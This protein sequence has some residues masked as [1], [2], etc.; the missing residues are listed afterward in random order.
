MHIGRTSKVI[1]RVSKK[2]LHEMKLIKHLCSLMLVVA[3]ASIVGACADTPGGKSVPEFRVYAMDAQSYG[4]TLEIPDTDDTENQDMT[5]PDNNLDDVS[6]IMEDTDRISEIKAERKSEECDS[7]PVEVRIMAV[8]D[9]LIHMPVVNAGKNE[10]GTYDYKEMYENILDEINAADLRVINQETILTADREEYSGYPC[11]GSPYEIGD[12]LIASG[13]NLVTCATNHSYDKKS[14]GIEDSVS[15]WKSHP[16][17]TAIGIYNSQD[18]FDEIAVVEIN[19]IRIACLNY[20]YGLNGFVLPSDRQYMVK[21]LYDKDAVAT[22]VRKADEI[23]DFVI[24]FPHWGTEYTH[25][26][27]AYQ[28]E[29]A[30]TFADNGA[31][32]II[33]THP[34]VIEPL[35]YI[36]ADDGHIVPCYYSLGNFISAQTEPNRILGG[37]AVVTVEKKDGIVTVKSADMLP[38]VTHR[39][40][41]TGKFTAY[42]LS[43]YN[44]ELGERHRLTARGKN[45][46]VDSLGCIFSEVM[47]Y[48]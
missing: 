28:K 44:D 4:A 47:G 13:F 34:H 23:S 2:G 25:K 12:A 8:G 20:T 3:T 27:T 31:D 10:D 45:V 9:N 46:T 26:T 42:M 1:L 19:G 35:E 24:V 43:D 41:I 11:F 36:T 17:V 40:S 37:M 29:W 16:E 33:G 18:D 39:D 5:A 14:K 7:Q 21:T 22:E 30:K 32:L 38:V 6:Q 15:Y 48:E